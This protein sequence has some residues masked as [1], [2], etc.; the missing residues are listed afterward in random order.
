MICSGHGNCTLW[1]GRISS[2]RELRR[3]QS[4]V[5]RAAPFGLT[6]SRR[7]VRQANTM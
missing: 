3:T 5:A 1:V 7:G 6:Q 2:A 4:R